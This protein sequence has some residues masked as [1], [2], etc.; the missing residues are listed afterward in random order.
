M[1]IDDPV[2]RKASFAQTVRAVL[3]SFIGLRK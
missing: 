2:H 3:W 1:A